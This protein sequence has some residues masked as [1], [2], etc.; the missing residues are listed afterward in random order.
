MKEYE[1][2]DATIYKG[3]YIETNFTNT[4]FGKSMYIEATT[5]N[6]SQKYMHTLELDIL[7]DSVIFTWDCNKNTDTKLKVLH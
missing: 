7:E 2:N 3:V 6:N 4:S 5:N 1:I